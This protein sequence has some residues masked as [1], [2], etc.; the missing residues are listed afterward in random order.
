MPDVF[1]SH[2]ECLDLDAWRHV[3]VAVAVCVR[4]LADGA[5]KVAADR[6][7][8]PARVY[9]E[10]PV[11]RVLVKAAA[12]DFLRPVAKGFKGLQ[13]PLGGPSALTSA[14]VG[15]V[16][17]SGLGYGGGYLAE[18]LMGD[19]V[20]PGHLRRTGMLLGGAAGAAPGVLSG[21]AKMQ[22]PKQVGTGM[23]PWTSRWPD[24]PGLDELPGPGVPLPASSRF[25]TRVFHDPEFPKLAAALSSGAFYTPSIPVD[26]FNNVVWADAKPS[27]PYGTRDPFGDN[28]QPMHTPPAVAAAVSGLVAGAGAATG[29]G[30]VS[31][32]HVALA[33]GLAGGQGYL[34]GMLAGKVLGA[35]AGLPPAAQQTL[36]QAGLWGGIVSGVASSVFGDR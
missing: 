8:D 14:I 7:H 32:Y 4:A 20:E 23:G 27:N 2:R 5:F 28:E 31:P 34:A 26:A 30:Y 36:Q 11:G 13:R 15:G 3:P 6:K 24:A 33:A 9:W 25:D 21:V 35:L 29:T 18:K 1:E 12:E 10:S 19:R 17:G 22:H 16:L